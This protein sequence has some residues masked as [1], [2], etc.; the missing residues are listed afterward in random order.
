LSVTA[1]AAGQLALT[2]D[3][4]ATEKAGSAV[5]V[6]G[7]TIVISQ[8]GLDIIVQAQGIGFG[9]EGTITGTIQ[10]VG[11][12]TAPVTADI[13][14]GQVSTSIDASVST[15]P[16][17]ASV[18][19]TI[20]EKVSSDTQSAF[21]AAA[22]QSNLQVQAVAYTMAVSKTN[23]DT[24]GPATITMTSPA[25]WVNQHGGH[26]AIQIARISDLGVAGM[27]ATS[28]R[29]MDSA[30]NM[31]FEGLSPDGLSIFGMISAKASQIK[32]EQQGINVSAIPQGTPVTPLTVIVGMATWAAGMVTGNIVF[33]GIG[34]TLLCV[35]SFVVWR[36][37]NKYDWFFRK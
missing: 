16:T 34:A 21:Q 30:G 4:P 2:I 9:P 1:T 18:T 10:S 37:R 31:V 13:G 6:R 28:Y 32:Q 12:A 7:E 17:G 20:S 8:P 11:I 15:I 35:V 14:I 33:M 23:L 26:S 22:A 29:G 24:T 27:L 25:A 19:T 36:R 5:S 3:V